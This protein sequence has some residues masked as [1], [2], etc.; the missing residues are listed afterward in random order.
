MSTNSLTE[1]I[2]VLAEKADIL[3]SMRETLEEEQRCIIEARPD[4]LVDNTS[5]AE[6]F[7][8]RL[9]VVNNR[10]KALLARTGKELGLPDAG[11][12]SPLIS[13]VD[14]ES[15]QKLRFLQKKCFF[16]AEAINRL[17]VINEGLIK[18]SLDIIDRS[19]FLFSRL[20]GGCE[21]YGSAGRIMNGKPAGGILYREI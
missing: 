2:S 15:R 17:L 12:L 5:R 20:L 8:T 10:F 16:A 7:M 13:G 18:H 1:L 9:N 4:R 14:P 19:I 11:S 3:E 6:G 21:T